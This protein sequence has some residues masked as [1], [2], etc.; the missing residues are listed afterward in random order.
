MYATGFEFFRCVQLLTQSE[1]RR[2]GC[3]IVGEAIHPVVRLRGSKQG[4]PRCLARPLAPRLQRCICA[5]LLITKVEAN[6]HV[7]DDREEQDHESVEHEDIYDCSEL[8][9]TGVEEPC[10]SLLQV[11]RPLCKPLRNA[12]YSA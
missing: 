11:Y 5:H 6:H 4:V 7:E 12:T 2:G 10:L 1:S 3:K 8:R 9:R